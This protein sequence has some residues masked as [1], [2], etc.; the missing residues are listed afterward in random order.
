MILL[1]TFPQ[2]NMH[3]SLLMCYSQVFGASHVSHFM[4]TQCHGYFQII[5]VNKLTV[6]TLHS[7]PFCIL[8]KNG[9]I[10]YKL[11]FPGF[12]HILWQIFLLERKYRGGRWSRDLLKSIRFLIKV[13]P[14]SLDCTAHNHE[15]SPHNCYNIANYEKEKMSLKIPAAMVTKRLKKGQFAD[16]VIIF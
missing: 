10:I 15:T 2:Q 12:D 6:S 16:S 14:Y 8:R 4:Q 5:T 3:G 11:Q 7:K 13:S 1:G 9:S